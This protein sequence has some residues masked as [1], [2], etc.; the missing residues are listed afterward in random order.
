MRTFIESVRAI[1]LHPT[2]EPCKADDH[3]ACVREC[4]CDDWKPCGCRNEFHLV[5][6]GS[7]HG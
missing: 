3:F 6:Q 4:D 5:A 1:F 7:D 2:C